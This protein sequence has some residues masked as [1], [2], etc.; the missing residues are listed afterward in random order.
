MP[1]DK[2]VEQT[3][4]DG[5]PVTLGTPTATDICDAEVLI[6]NNAPSVFPL[7]VTTVT[8]T[9]TD[10]SGNKASESMKVTVVDTTPPVLTAPADATVE[11]ATR[12]GTVVSLIPT[13]TDIC[14]ADVAITSDAPSVFP[15]GVTTVT[16][17]A[18][19]DSGNSASATTRVTVVDTTPPT[20]SVTLSPNTIWSPNHKMVS[21]RATVTAED[22]CD[23]APVKTLTS[24]TSDE[25]D[26]APGIG[27]GTTKKDI[28]A[29]IGTSV[30]IFKLR[31]ERA[32]EG[33]GRVY[34]V[35]Y[36]ATDAS[37]NPASTSATVVVPL[38]K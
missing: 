16:F 32:G 6:T 26:D 21:I 22:I 11:Q 20:I 15:L 31:A 19:D 10:D 13:A 23:A 24:I 14:D 5:T 38:E 33:D 8:F 9:A 28:D 36:T 30:F 34:T 17:T 1:A 7:G 37:G 2:I 4:K 27:D 29:D 35:T 3:S 18:T 25:P 12:D